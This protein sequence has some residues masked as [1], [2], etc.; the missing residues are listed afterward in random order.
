M[1]VLAALV[2]LTYMVI[3]P[4]KGSRDCPSWSAIVKSRGFQ[5]YVVS[6]AESARLDI[7]IPESFDDDDIRLLDQFLMR[8]PIAV[9]RFTGGSGFCRST[10][11]MKVRNDR[12]ALLLVICRSSSSYLLSD[13]FNNPYVSY[14]CVVAADYE[15]SH[16][17]TPMEDFLKAYYVNRIQGSGMLNFTLSGDRI[18]VTVNQEKQCLNSSDVPDSLL[19]YQKDLPLTGA[20]VKVACLYPYVCED[21]AFQLLGDLFRDKWAS[22][23]AVEFGKHRIPYTT[24]AMGVHL[25]PGVMLYFPTVV[26]VN[27][28]YPAVAAPCHYGYSGFSFFVKNLKPYSK[29][30]ILILPF[31]L[32]VW[33]MLVSCLVGCL[34]VVF[35]IRRVLGCSS[36]YV[37]ASPFVTTLMLQSFSMPR[38]S[39]RYQSFRLLLG[40]WIIANFVMTVAFLSCLTSLLN[41][42]PL[43]G[44]IVDY[45][46]VKDLRS[47]GFRICVLSSADEVLFRGTTAGGP[48]EKV[49]LG[50][51]CFHS[52]G[53]IRIADDGKDTFMVYG[54]GSR[55]HEM[56]KRELLSKGY[57]ESQTRVFSYP[58]GPE[59]RTT[60]PYRRAMGRLLRQSFEG[61]LFARGVN[62][63]VLKFATQHD[64]APEQTLTGNECLTV[65]SL[66][67]YF[68]LWAIGAAISSIAF[69]A[70][71]LF[72]RYRG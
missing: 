3:F 33:L 31:S 12:R 39:S 1:V 41:E 34:L 28:M 8:N 47:Q 36:D 53:R 58:S 52:S 68:L 72:H 6:A 4:S 27:P 2:V 25:F 43:E 15:N 70:E 7:G 32:P 60:S 67:P 24:A 38:K 35:L 45:T 20:K 29:E 37:P 16:T 22:F 11:C 61:G 56:L 40:V 64:A 48:E 10:I 50:D 13:I 59:V 63:A 42:V 57:V 17:V 44:K 21:P 23:E 9:R 65:G 19:P 49:N 30:M 55:K 46:S 71:C 14:L 66:R 54:K 5:R 62:L 51:I 69:G 26:L 18:L